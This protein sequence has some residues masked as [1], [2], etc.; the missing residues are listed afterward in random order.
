MTS[1]AAPRLIRN[2]FSPTI[3]VAKHCADRKTKWRQREEKGNAQAHVDPARL[4]DCRYFL[5]L[6]GPRFFTGR[7]DAVASEGTVLAS[8]VGQP[9]S[10]LQALGRNRREDVRRTPQ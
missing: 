3:P 5:G 10:D 6:A 7:S 4:G 8:C 9:S 1:R 2:R